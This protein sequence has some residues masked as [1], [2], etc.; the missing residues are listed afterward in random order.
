MY[1]FLL[2]ILI[3]DA[4]VLVA[5]V[6]MQA[7]KGGG[8]A[9]SF[10]GV[11]TAADSFIGTRQAGNVLTR[12]SW[13]AGGIFLGLAFTLQL[14]STRGRAPTSILDRGLGT[15]APSAA[16]ATPPPQSVVPI[17]TPEKGATPPTGSE[18]KNP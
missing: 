6:L 1:T 11:S 14:M 8:L 3:L 15:P 4:L 16:P 18:K 12:I 9:A 10:G 7:A 5:S 17:G 13:W 2:V